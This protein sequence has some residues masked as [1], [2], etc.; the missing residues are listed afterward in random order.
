M[1]FRKSIRDCFKAFGDNKW[2]KYLYIL[3]NGFIFAAVHV[4]GITTSIWDYLYI[5]PYMALGCS[6]AS[7]YYKT[8][9][10]FSTISMHALHNT[11]AVILYLI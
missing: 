1:I 3:I 11:V 8:D 7:L 4:I 2:T 6:F 9:N 5:I 10:I